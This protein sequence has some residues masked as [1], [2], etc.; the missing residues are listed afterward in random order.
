MAGGCRVDRASE[1]QAPSTHPPED[2][3]PQ[4][5]LPKREGLAYTHGQIY[6]PGSHLPQ[7]KVKM[8]ETSPLKA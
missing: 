7:R 3:G 8:L 4:N 2:V 1:R 6:K 5:L